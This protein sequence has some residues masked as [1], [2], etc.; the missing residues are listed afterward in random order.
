MFSQEGNTSPDRLAI[1]GGAPVVKIPAP[2]WPFFDDKDRVALNEVLESRVWGGYHESV[3]QLEKLFAAFH[4]AE[5]GIALVNG[6]M[7]L[8][9]A[10]TAAG[11]GPGDEVIVPPITFVASATSIAR[12]GAT[13]VFVDIDAST[14][15]LNP[16]LV[17]KSIT[18][19]TRGIVAVHFAGH[20]VDLDSLVSLCDQHGLVL[21]EDCA[22]AHGAAWQEQRIGSFGSFGSFSF[23]AS[24]NMTAGEGGML[25]TNDADLAERARSISNQGRRTGGAWY[26]HQ[27]LGTNARMTGFQA[28]LLLNQLERLPAELSTR[29]DDA[30]YLR[31]K[32]TR[33]GGLVPTPAILDERVTVHGYHLFSMRYDA[34]SWAGLPR[35]RFVKALQAEGVPVTTGYPH[36]IYRNELF[37]H[38]PNVVQPCPAAEAYC[39]SSVWLPHNALLADE[40]WLDDVVTAITKV[41]D[42]VEEL[43]AIET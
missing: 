4:G 3:G 34:S 6:T 36:P 43:T 13:P 21:I 10:L 24:K 18:E 42:A 39:Q 41:R 2:S 20:P 32:L 5:H 11:I 35:E 22:H 26:E 28:V 9:I 16:A 15:N 27:S 19:R 30:A 1:F 38:H 37:Q 12:V 14:I 17:E 33:I 40:N 29:M 7:S 31:E 8:E 23:Q 25:I